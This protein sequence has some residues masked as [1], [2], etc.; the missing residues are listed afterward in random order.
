MILSGWGRFPRIDCER[1]ALRSSSDAAAVVAAAGS[2]I[3]RGNGRS[4]GDAALNP[5]CVLDM[6]LNDRILAF[7]PETG[8]ITCEAGLLLSDLLD[9]AVTRGFFPPVTPGTKF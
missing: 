2:L 8:R 1:I 7:D 4:Y 6:R 9:F 5:A 3:P